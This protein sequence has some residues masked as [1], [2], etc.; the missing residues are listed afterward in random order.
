[1]PSAAT[2]R[3]ASRVLSPWRTRTRDGS[4]VSTSVTSA[5]ITRDSVGRAWRRI[6]CRAARGMPT[7]GAPSSR[8]S[9]SPSIIASRRPSGVR[10]PPVYWRRAAASTASPTPRAASARIP[11][12]A[13][14]M[15]APAS[16]RTAA[17]STTVTSHPASRSPIAAASPPIPPPTT[18]ALLLLMPGPPVLPRCFLQL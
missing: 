15:P 8:S 4:V 17:R 11:L 13:S 6:R 7:I 16:S 2:T 9:A 10:V 14:E 3:A 5:P 1:M 18:T 12:A